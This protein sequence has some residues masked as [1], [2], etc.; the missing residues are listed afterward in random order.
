VAVIAI[1]EQF[2]D[3]NPGAARIELQPDDM[4]DSGEVS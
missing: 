4:P 3:S 1:A 2:A